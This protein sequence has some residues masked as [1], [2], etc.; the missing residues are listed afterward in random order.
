MIIV[1]TS[2]QYEVLYIF[3]FAA[4]KK[5]KKKKNLNMLQHI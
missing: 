1:F 4:K 3:F 2:D 5:K